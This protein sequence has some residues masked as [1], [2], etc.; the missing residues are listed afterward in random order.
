V[1]LA[2]PTRL[3][4]GAQVLLVDDVL[5]SGATVAE[6]ARVLLDEGGAAAVDVIV[7]ARQPWRERG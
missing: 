3:V 6:C 2:F 1:A 5:T 4:R 7:L